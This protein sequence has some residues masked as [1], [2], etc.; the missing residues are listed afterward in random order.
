M[1]PELFDELQHLRLILSET[2]GDVLS[3]Y[4]K[5]AHDGSEYDYRDYDGLLCPC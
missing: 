4:A 3:G 5:L 1:H 2:I